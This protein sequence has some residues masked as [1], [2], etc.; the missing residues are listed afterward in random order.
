[1]DPFKRYNCFKLLRHIFITGH[2]I[3]LKVPNNFD[4][5]RR[6][7]LKKLSDIVERDDNVQSVTSITD[8][9]NMNQN[10]V[11]ESEMNYNSKFGKNESPKLKVLKANISDSQIME[12]GAKFHLSIY[13]IMGEDVD[14]GETVGEWNYNFTKG[15]TIF[16]KELYRERFN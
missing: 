13:S 3:L 5:V 2:A 14:E 15:T 12:G 1:M 4:E 8:P 11:I 16:E 7:S 6:E 9:K 10:N